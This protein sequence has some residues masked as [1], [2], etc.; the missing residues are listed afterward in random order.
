VE[1]VAEMIRGQARPLVG[2][3]M[4]AGI[5]LVLVAALSGCHPSADGGKPNKPAGHI[6]L[7]AVLDDQGRVL[8][9]TERVTFPSDVYSFTVSIDRPD[10]TGTGA[11]FDPWIE[12]LV[13][14][15]DQNQPV[16][17][18][19]YI[20]KPTGVSLAWP[21]RTVTLRYRMAGATYHPTPSVPGRFLAY[22]TGISIPSTEGFSRTITIE[23]ALNLACAEPG[24]Q[25][26]VCGT[27]TGGTW[28]VT[29]PAGADDTGVYAQVETQ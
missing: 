22:V 11:D 4:G 19:S 15:A 29:V 5:A 28:S 14:E 12:R 6:Q 1:G 24:G 10:R 9:V 23:N 8:D 13:V 26:T 25:L 27:E 21:A 2:R 3:V 18:L 17:R 16:Q 20:W 7:S